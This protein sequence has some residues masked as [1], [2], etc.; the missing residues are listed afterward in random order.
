MVAVRSKAQEIVAMH[1]WKIRMRYFPCQCSL[2]KC[3]K[4]RFTQLCK[5]HFLR[6]LLGFYAFVI[7]HCC[8]V[9]E[10]G[11]QKHQICRN[12]EVSRSKAPA[13]IENQVRS[14]FYRLLTLNINALKTRFAEVNGSCNHF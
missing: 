12:E 1:Q 10:P 13:V 4:V 11:Q 6:M 7:L 5:L 3:S 2:A 14:K 9:D 8:I